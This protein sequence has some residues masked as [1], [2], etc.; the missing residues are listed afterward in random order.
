MYNRRP[1]KVFC[2]EDGIAMLCTISDFSDERTWRTGY[3]RDTP[4]RIGARQ[5]ANEIF[6]WICS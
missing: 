2:G 5:S 1:L 4:W 6:G 3:P